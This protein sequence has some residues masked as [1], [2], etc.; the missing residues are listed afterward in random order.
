VTPAWRVVAA[1]FVLSLTV[2]NSVASFGVFLPALADAF[3]WSRGAISVA[4]SLNL[5]VG[6][7]SGL[8]VGAIADRHGPRLVLLTTLAMAAAGF[9]L[10]ST[11]AHLWQLYLFIG[12]MGG[13]GTSGFYVVGAATVSRW[14][15]RGR[16]LAL[17]IVLA[18]FNLSFVTGGPAAAWLV[19]HVGWRRGYLVIAGALL[20]LGG[21]ASLFVRDPPAR[22]API[23]GR[24]TATD[25]SGMG[26]RGALVDRRFWSLMAAWILYG[27]VSMTM[28]VHVVAYARDRG[29]D[30]A[31]AA[32]ALTTFGLG[33]TVGRL[34]CGP[35]SDRLGG[36]SILRVCIALQVLALVALPFGP[37][38]EIL[39]VILGLFGLGFTGADIV[40][41]RVIPDVFG[42]RSLGAITGMLSLGWRLGA[43]VGPTAAGFV[44]DATGSYAIPFSLAPVAIVVGY[45]CFAL[46]SRTRRR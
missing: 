16:G 1:L 36:D 3:G 4:F 32:L 28:S 45:A 5:F 39:L 43:A 40:Y 33:S 26:I 12:V 25:G 8:A 41:V 21:S 38:Q 44:H 22:P 2:S 11:V 24:A 20:F 42:L 46:G 23:S 13:M 7:F 6:G 27:S 37:S 35:L 19:E 17:A 18:A 31:S 15:E 10:A 29:V 14:F 30:L 34:A 9:A